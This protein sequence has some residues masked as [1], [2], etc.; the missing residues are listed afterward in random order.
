M[1]VTVIVC[2][3]LVGCLAL[4]QWA[5]NAPPPAPIGIVC[6]CL[7][8]VST[9][10][11]L[12][13]ALRKKNSEMVL[14]TTAIA[15]ALATVVY[16]DGTAYR[17]ALDECVHRQT[18]SYGVSVHRSYDIWRDTVVCDITGVHGE[19]GGITFRTWDLLHD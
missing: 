19:H 11:V 17:R 1:I 16:T 12:D 10:L 18:L 5:A 8:L 2:Q 14:G 6:I 7:V 3:M 9:L 15:F 4:R 13:R